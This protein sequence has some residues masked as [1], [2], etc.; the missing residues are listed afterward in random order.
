MHPTTQLPFTF[1]NTTILI[2]VDFVINLRHKNGKAGRFAIL[3]PTQHVRNLNLKDKRELFGRVLQ[4][5]TSHNYTGEFRRSFLLLSS[6]P[7]S[8]P[9]DNETT[10]KITYIEGMHKIHWQ[11]VPKNTHQLSRSHDQSPKEGII[12]ALADSL[13]SLV[14]SRKQEPYPPNL[15]LLASYGELDPVPAQDDGG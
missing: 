10:N 8:C 9:C 13:Q 1:C 2:L 4:C 14:P 6:D 3:N 5:R 12:I 7:A 11:P 15:T